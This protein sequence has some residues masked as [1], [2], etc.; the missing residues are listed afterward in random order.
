M[1]GE[2]GWSEEL[3]LVVFVLFEFNEGGVEPCFVVALVD[4]G[5]EEV[6]RGVF[7]VLAGCGVFLVVVI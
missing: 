6:V 1:G 3:F 4:F 2:Y 5:G 7:L